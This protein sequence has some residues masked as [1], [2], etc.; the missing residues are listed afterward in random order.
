VVG[1]GV[2]VPSQGDIVWLH[3][4]PQAGHEQ[5]GHRPALV[6][7]AKSYNKKRGLALFCPLTSK[8]KG[9]PF[10]VVLPND[11]KIGGGV[12][13]AD[14]IRSLDWRERKAK[15]VCKAP[16]EVLEEVMA[17]IAALL[18]MTRNV[19]SLER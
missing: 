8:I 19:V 11:S 17:K 1:K 15:F 5:A 18:E 16:T 9:Y 3:F 2:Y 10:E 6:L 13:L 12:V 7:S 4:N 14:Q